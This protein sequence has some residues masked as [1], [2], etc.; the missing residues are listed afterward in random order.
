MKPQQNAI[1]TVEVVI[2][3]ILGLLFFL[4]FIMEYFDY[5]H[6]LWYGECYGNNT[7][8]DFFETDYKN[9]VK[10]HDSTIQKL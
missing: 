1:E 4:L 8:E 3:K 6:Q 9:L 5:V 2:P 10:E 7:N